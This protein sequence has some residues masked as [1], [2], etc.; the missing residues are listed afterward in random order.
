MRCGLY[1]FYVL[2]LL[3]FI[4][5]CL[6][7]YLKSREIAAFTINFRFSE[8]F[9][10]ILGSVIRIFYTIITIFVKLKFA[11]KAFLD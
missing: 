2:I 7:K 6:F 8:P 5:Y 9:G 4:L 10:V 11:F 1:I 3:F